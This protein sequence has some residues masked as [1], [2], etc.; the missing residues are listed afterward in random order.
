M[1]LVG[2]GLALIGVLYLWL[3]AIT[4]VDPWAAEEAINSRTLPMAYGFCFV[5]ACW[6]L[7]IKGRGRAELAP[8]SARRVVAL[9]ACL[10]GFAAAVPPLGLWG[11][12]PVLL[13]PALWVMGER[14]WWALTAL[15]GVT[16]VVGWVVIELLLDV[17]VP[18]GLWFS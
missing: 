1:Q 3:A 2:I 16:A 15:P 4:P 9:L 11:A 8:R 17:Y 13:V 18:A 10:I 5:I 12:I 7:M 14:R 6:G